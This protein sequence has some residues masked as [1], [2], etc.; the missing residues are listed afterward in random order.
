MIARP[1]FMVFPPLSVKQPA[2]WTNI[3]PAQPVQ[4]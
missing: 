3:Q 4:P 2:G 1:F